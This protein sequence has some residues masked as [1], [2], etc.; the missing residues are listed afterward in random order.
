MNR[1]TSHL[2][3]VAVKQPR[4][5]GEG[6]REEYRMIGAVIRPLSGTLAARM[7]GEPLQ[8]TR[9]L[10][11]WPGGDLAVGMGVCVDVGPQD[12]PDWRVV[13]VACWPRHCQA[14]IRYLPP[15][16]RRARHE[17]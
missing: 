2:R 9:L 12:A 1:M 14:H 3:Q 11:T 16:E 4:G 7:Y 10:L 13:Y 6:Y 15:W 5:N 17:D 8:E